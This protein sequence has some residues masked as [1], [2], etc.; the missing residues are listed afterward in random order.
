MSLKMG[1]GIG[2]NIFVVLLMACF[3]KF[4]KKFFPKKNIESYYHCYYYIQ[5]NIEHLL[6]SKKLSIQWQ[7][8]FVYV[9][10]IYYYSSKYIYMCI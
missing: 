10:C 8:Y 1:I 7:I 5:K 2:L 3:K 6:S 9:S 4:S